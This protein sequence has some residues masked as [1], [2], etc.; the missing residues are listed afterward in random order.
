MSE[1]AQ[2]D[3]AVTHRRKKFEKNQKQVA[4]KDD[5]EIHAGALNDIVEKVRHAMETHIPSISRRVYDN[6][7]G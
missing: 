4:R 5:Q 3:W 2:I 7:E 1:G 6:D